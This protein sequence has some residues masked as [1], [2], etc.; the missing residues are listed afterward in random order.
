MQKLIF[1]LLLISGQALAQELPAAYQAYREKYPEGPSP[2]RWDSAYS[3][4]LPEKIL[5]ASLRSDPL[6]PMVD[7]STTPYLRPVFQQEGPSCGQAAMVCYNFTYEMAYIRHQPAMFPQTQYPSHFTWNFQNGGNGWYGVSYFHSIE[8]LKKCGTMNCYDYGGFADDGL[9]W[10]NGY[11]YYYNGMYNR[12]KGVY[13]IKTGTEE[14]LLALKHWLYDHMG[15][16]DAGGVASYYANSPWNAGV[17]AD[18]TPEGGKHVIYAWYPAATHAMTIIGY[19]DSIC[20]DYNSDGHYTNNIDLNEDGIIDPRDWEIGAFKFV[21]SWGTESGDSGFFYLMYKCLAETFENG[22]VWNREVHILDVDEDYMPMMTYKITLKHDNRQKIKI[23]AGVS[24]DTADQAPAWMMDF[25]IFDYQGDVHYLQGHDTAESQKSLQFGLDIT[26]LLGNLQPGL[27]ARFFFLVDENDPVDEG[28]GQISAFSLMDY[29][30]GQQE[31]PASG[32]PLPLVNDSRTITSVIYTPDFD[33][34]E[35]TTDSLPPFTSNTPYSFQLSA[36]GGSTP[37]TWAPVYNY[38]IEQSEETFP[39]VTETQVL[40]A[41]SDTIVAVPLGFDFTFYGKTYDTVWMHKNGHLQLSADQLSWPYLRE[42]DLQFRSFAMIDAVEH[43]SLTLVLADGDGGWVERTDSCI[44][45]RWKASLPAQPGSTDVNFAVRLWQ[46]GRIDII[47]GNSTLDGT[48]WISGISSGN[49]QDFMLSPVSGAVNIQP[50]R[51]ISFIPTPLPPQVDLSESGLLTILPNSSEQI[52]DLS[53]RVTDDHGLSD[54]KTLQFTSGLYLYFTVDAG[55]DDRADYGDTVNLDLRIVNGSQATLSDPVITLNADDQYITLTDDICNPGNLLPGQEISI[56]GAFQ[57]IVSV[58]VPDQ[59]DLLF[60]AALSSG[61]NNWAK[62]LL[63]KAHAPYLQVKQYAID[64]GDDILD[65][66]ETAPLMITLQNSGSAPIEDVNAEIT[67]LDP[68]IQVI[69]EDVLEY[70]SIDRG[71]SV[72]QTCMLHAGESV[73]NGFVA[74]VLL[75]TTSA[76]GITIQDTLVLNIG[77]APV[78]VIDMDPNHHSGPGILS[79][80]DQLDVISF[81]EY[82][83]SQAINHYQSLFICLGFQPNNHVLTLWEGQRLSEF[84]DIGGKIYM[85]GRKTWRDD[86]GTPVHP[87]FNISTGQTVGVY[88]TIVGTNGTFTQ[89]MSLNNDATVPFSFYYMEPVD[90][91]FSILQ[92]NNTLQV[93]AVANDAGTYKTIASLF[94]YGTL[95]DISPNATRDLMIAYLNFFSISV[96]PVG[97]GEQGG[98]GAWGHGGMVVW[99]NPASSQLTVGSQRSAVGGQQSAISNLQSITGFEILDMYGCEPI[100]SDKHASLPIKIDISTLAPGLYILRV[101]T[102]DQ[103]VF[104]SKFLKSRN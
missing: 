99:P 28:T 25:P 34:V 90:P 46:N 47:H 32:L 36:D 23:L 50:G 76:P 12:V 56:P 57:F 100:Q 58:D 42:P 49:K 82:N 48:D 17:L 69:G 83:I 102:Q 30:S 6:P 74:H 19:N 104:V 51:K 43:N 72:T 86:P 95:S 54:V 18:T 103:Q 22:G 64:T 96:D 85:E 37:Y 35:I 1:I 77:K 39:M 84:L 93:C 40:V 81:Y 79:M 5:P 89:G 33:K 80:L 63:L 91:A 53:F 16:G 44:T 38:R 52:Y 9:R 2:D 20:W 71:M 101:K 92:D 75:T 60:E 68:D 70:G 94:E 8:I 14:G 27:P 88:D 55:G 11:N 26:P 7:N 45:F 41:N 4:N 65:P 29:T 3:K 13:S 67:P 98:M 73:P 31:I 24:Q 21:N 10:I 62:T 61:E 59:C 66:G 15:E 97:I 78:L 87:K